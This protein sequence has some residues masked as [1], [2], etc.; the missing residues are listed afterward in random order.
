MLSANSGYSRYCCPVPKA[1]NRKSSIGRCL[2]SAPGNCRWLS[3][4]CHRTLRK[5]SGFPV[6][7]LLI[8]EAMPR[9]RQGAALP[10]KYENASESHRLSA[11][12]AAS[13]F[14]TYNFLTH[15]CLFHDSR[16]TIHDLRVCTAV[17]STVFCWALT[18]ERTDCPR[19]VS[20][21][22]I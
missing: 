4:L 10:R 20:K 11:K 8:C 21:S 15:S 14:T 19:L 1:V 7:R 16:F 9:L 13:R 18:T 6:S 3:R 17:L 22:W 5:A 12:V 2:F